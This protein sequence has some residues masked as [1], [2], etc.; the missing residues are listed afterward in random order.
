MD[1]TPFPLQTTFQTRRENT[2]TKTGFASLH[3]ALKIK[4]QVAVVEQL[5]TP[6]PNHG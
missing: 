4:K 2:Q 6:D 5:P 1:L 3:L